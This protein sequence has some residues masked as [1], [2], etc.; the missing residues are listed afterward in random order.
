MNDIVMCT[1]YG[2]SIA[3][4]C[5]RHTRGDPDD[6]NQCSCNFEYT[7]HED[8]DTKYEYFIPINVPERKVNE[9]IRK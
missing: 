6:I 1:A 5:Y 2:C 4:K 7:C 9:I 8:M 3:E